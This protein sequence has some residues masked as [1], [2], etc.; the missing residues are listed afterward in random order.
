[1]E[2]IFEALSCGSNYSIKQVLIAIKFSNCQNK[3]PEDEQAGFYI[4]VSFDG[5]GN[6][7]LITSCGN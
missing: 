3:R 4:P 5:R 2:E 6:P 7:G 1:L